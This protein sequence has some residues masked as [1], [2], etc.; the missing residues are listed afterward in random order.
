[1]GPGELTCR[2]RRHLSNVRVLSHTGISHPGLTWRYNAAL[3]AMQCLGYS[4]PIYARFDLAQQQQQQQPFA[5][6]CLSVHRAC[7]ALLHDRLERSEGSMGSK[8]L[9][10]RLLPFVDARGVVR[11]REGGGGSGGRQRAASDPLPRARAAGGENG[12]LWCLCDPTDLPAVALGGFGLG[13]RAAPAELLRAAGAPAGDAQALMYCADSRLIPAQLLTPPHS[14]ADPAPSTFSSAS[15][16]ASASTPAYPARPTAT[17][18]TTATAN[19]LLQLPAPILS[20]LASYLRA[21][22][23]IALSQTC[24]EFRLYF[25]AESRVWPQMCRKALGY[26]PRLLHNHQMAEYYMR[27]RG[28]E[29]AERSVL[30]QRSRIERVIEQICCQQE[31]KREVVFLN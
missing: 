17:T 23:I 29:R 9:L 2:D 24:A 22:E 28:D 27:V 21:A 12:A 3:N 19:Q 8:D 7:Y 4:C 16:S 15:A 14:P 20:L 5:S 30:V 6:T 10:R 26:T 11:M 31:R 13:G 1:M 18:A 25:A